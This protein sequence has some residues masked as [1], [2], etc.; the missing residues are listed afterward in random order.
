MA[1]KESTE[2]DVLEARY[3]EL[4]HSLTVY[5]KKYF[6]LQEQYPPE[7]E[8]LIQQLGRLDNVLAITKGEVVE[9]G[10]KINAIKTELAEL[11]KCKKKNIFLRMV[12]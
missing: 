8:Y 9:F 2:L 1:K 6:D 7:S 10:R 5:R 12:G 4:S 11:A 3:V